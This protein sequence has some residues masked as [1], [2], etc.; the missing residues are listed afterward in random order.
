M[1]PMPLRQRLHQLLTATRTYL[2]SIVLP[3]LWAF[4][5]T[6]AAVLVNS[7]RMILRQTRRYVTGL[8]VV[9]ILATLIT[10][11][12]QL[13]DRQS[14]RV[15]RAWDVVLRITNPDQG[16]RQTTF[17][18]DQTA[19]ETGS[20]L[21]Q[22]LEFLNRDFAGFG[23]LEEL[24]IV[25]FISEALTGNPNRQCLIPR[26]DRE[27][28][29]GLRA[30]GA[31][32]VG[33][34]LAG[35]VLYGANLASTT[36]RNANL[37]GADMRSANLLNADL[38][39]ANLQGAN[40]QGAELSNADLRT[41][42]LRHAELSNGEFPDAG[43]AYLPFVDL[44]NAYMTHST[45]RNVALFGADLSGVSLGGAELGGA[46]LWLADLSGADL[47]D[48]RNL[49]Q[50]QVDSAC[51]DPSKVARFSEASE[52]DISG[53]VELYETC[54]NMTRD[55]HSKHALLEF[56][57]KLS[58]ESLGQQQH[59]LYEMLNDS[60]WG[61]ERTVVTWLTLGEPNLASMVHGAMPVALTR[62]Y[63]ALGV[64]LYREAA[65]KPGG[66]VL[67][68]SMSSFENDEI[69]VLRRRLC[70]DAPWVTSTL[71]QTP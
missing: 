54:R 28:L 14:E 26:K 3:Y 55:P 42:D 30:G 34:D 32:L 22:A 12:I 49:T 48:V 52:F 20:A 69:E 58:I 44:S 33:I 13:D 36:L 8:T 15:F 24:G 59:G 53:A 4:A 18:T 7:R 45:L 9:G 67:A 17:E 19:F 60:E 1:K 29:Q 35:G 43:R 50:A 39:D 47:R 38:R 62:N 31:D 66:S 25:Q 56:L 57:F 2:V 11:W 64:V 46:K 65:E 16:D 37:E 51:V 41:A 23:C 61:Y 10:S 70:G 5:R 63:G 40:L 68:V 6:R 71:C 21:R 27:S